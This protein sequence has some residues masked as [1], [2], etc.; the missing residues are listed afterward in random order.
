[1]IKAKIILVGLALSL[2][3][4]ACI[5]AATA[6]AA[7]DSPTV[8]DVQARDRLIAAQEAL[9][10]TYR[11]RFN[12]DTQ[13]VPGGCLG[14]QPARSEASPTPFT[15]TP[16]SHH[17]QV[18]DQLVSSQ[19]A[20]LNAYRCRFNIDTQVVPGGCV[21]DVPA[22]VNARDRIAVPQT[23]PSGRCADSISGGAYDWEECAWDGYWDDRTYNHSLADTEGQ[24]LVERIWA[25]VDTEGKPSDPPT[26][27][28]VP[29]G[30]T[31]AQAVEGGVII[32]CYQPEKHHI[33]RLDSFLQTLL[34]ETAHALI[35][36]HPSVQACRAHSDPHRYNTCVHNDI[37]RCVSDHLYVQYAGIPSAGVCGETPDTPPAPS[38]VY[39]WDSFRPSDGGLIAMVPAFVHTRRF[40]YEDSIDWLIVSCVE[41]NLVIFLSFEYG[42]LAGQYLLGDR[43]PVMHAFLPDAWFSWEDRRQR[44]FL[45]SNRK[46]SHWGEFFN[47]HGAFLPSYQQVDFI[48]AAVN[49]NNDWLFVSVSNYDDSDFGTFLFSLDG[50]NDHILPVI[51]K[52][53]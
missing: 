11:C 26:S 16:T 1:M 20:L 46:L 14:D 9:L 38:S 27:E 7:A 6:S 19:E 44:E 53:T 21:G 5:E 18:R 39:S 51:E 3:G 23:A 35:A 10:N 17:I 22:P 40:P 33:R 52:C 50:A 43:I 13:V 28:L 37:F 34:H 25:E 32:A 2:I 31:C 29:A 12:I 48:D 49:P 41:D 45:T 8:A 30:S 47:N 4:A 15:G 36:L 24:A 42:Y